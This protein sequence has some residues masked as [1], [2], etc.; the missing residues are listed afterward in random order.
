[1]SEKTKIL[2]VSD[3]HGDHQILESLISKYKTKVNAMFHCGDS[4]FSPDDEVFNYFKVVTGNCDYDPRFA[5]YLVS[6]VDG[7]RVL[8]THG[9]LLRV[10]TGLERLGLL[11]QEKQ[12]QI[13]LFGHTHRLGAEYVHGCLFLNPGSI[14]YPRGEYSALGGT[15]AIIEVSAEQFEICYY[16]R[17]FTKIPDLQFAFPRK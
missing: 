16:D 14:S 13:A 9:H 17:S 6:D 8:L 15:Y 7:T 5:E 10:N 11:A 2:V 4:E 3:N 12:A 1:M